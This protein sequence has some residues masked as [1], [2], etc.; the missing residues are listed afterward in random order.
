MERNKLDEMQ[1]QKRNAIGNQCFLLLSW[2]IILDVVAYGLGIRWLQYPVNIFFIM[3]VCFTYYG[4]RIALA[5]AI[6]GVETNK[7]SNNGK[8]NIV[9][10]TIFTALSAIISLLINKSNLI[11]VKA[12]GSQNNDVKILFFSS[13]IMLVVVLVVTIIATKKINKDNE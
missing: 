12:T 13:L 9:Y 11:K 4:V 8:K 6:A 10:L 3:L 7:T 1:L 5:G 2:L